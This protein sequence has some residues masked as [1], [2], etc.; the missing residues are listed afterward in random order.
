MTARIS[1]GIVQ[2]VRGL[3]FGLSRDLILKADVFFHCLKN[4]NIDKLA[5]GMTCLYHVKPDTR[6]AG[7]IAVDIVPLKDANNDDIHHVVHD[8]F[9]A[10]RPQPVLLTILP[11][12]SEENRERFMG[13]MLYDIDRVDTPEKYTESLNVI[14]LIRS[15]GEDAERSFIRRLANL[16]TG[17]YKFR[18]WVDGQSDEIDASTVS[19]YYFRASKNDRD[20]IAKS[21][22]S[23]ALLAIFLSVLENGGR[24]TDLPNDKICLEMLD[25]AKAW[26]PKEYS[27]LTDRIWERSSEPVQLQLWLRGFSYRFDSATFRL[28]F[29]L[30]TPEEQFLFI[31][32]LAKDHEEERITLTVE[33]LKGLVRFEQD[34]GDDPSIDCSVDIVLQAIIDLSAG[35]PLSVEQQIG[36]VLA[37]HFDRKA[38]AKYR[39]KEL[40]DRC[41]GRGTVTEDKRLEEGSPKVLT[42]RRSNLIPAGVVFCEGH[43]APSMDRTHGVEFWFCRN[44]PCFM[45]C[46]QG[47]KHAQWEKYTLRDLLHVLKIPFDEAQYQ[48]FLGY[49]N[50]LN[51]LL[52]HLN[53]RSCGKILSPVGKSNYAFYLATRFSCTNP[54]CTTKKEVYLNHCLHPRCG[55]VVDSRDAA[56][57]PNSLHVCPNCFSCCSTAKFGARLQ[58]LG[59]TAPEHLKKLVQE[60]GGHM[61]RGIHFC[62]KCGNELVGGI[63]K[64][65][66]TL[67]WLIASAKTDRRIWKSDRRQDGGW[68]FVVDFPEEKYTTLAAMGFEVNAMASGNGRLIAEPREGKTFTLG[69]CPNASCER[70]GTECQPNFSFRASANATK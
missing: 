29:L 68:W 11:L 50:R 33:M 19:T 43:K 25:R 49:I 16:A 12:L 27:S 2:W 42:Y 55:N 67:K 63:E 28:Q 31:R 52:A 48:T 47:H 40:F 58:R 22:P 53:C 21:V 62:F 45:P 41:E 17:P 15:L 46:N 10:L 59:D 26:P 65:R 1:I 32:R 38:F 9:S 24:I 70:H 3:E 7:W 18:L 8:H 6:R 61:E 13:R 20:K 35:K 30:L 54:D 4:P 66:L 39:V 57:C 23:S 14:A 69:H 56:K 44:V 36:H 60:N 34:A 51:D 5:Q 64:Y 37:K